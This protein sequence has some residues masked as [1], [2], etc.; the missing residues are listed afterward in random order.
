MIDI[1]SFKQDIADK[2]LSASNHRCVLC[3]ESNE[4][5]LVFHEIV[6][7]AIPNLYDNTGVD[8]FP[9]VP[10]EDRLVVL[11]RSC[12]VKIET[13]SKSAYVDI[14]ENNLWNKIPKISNQIYKPLFSGLLTNVRKM[15][16]MN[17]FSPEIYLRP[18]DVA[19]HSYWVALLSLA[20]ADEYL[21]D[22]PVNRL[23][24]LTMALFHDIVEIVTTDVPT[25]IK[26]ST[27]KTN[28]FY[29]IVE[30]QASKELEKSLGYHNLTDII[31]EVNHGESVEA[32]IVR[33][34]DRISAIIYASEEA[35]L[36]NRNF[37][38]IIRS[39][40]S[41]VIKTLDNRG[42]QPDWFIE[43]YEDIKNWLDDSISPT[44]LRKG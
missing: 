29:E 35:F 34:A 15:A 33:A 30:K 13:L 43:L 32:Q 40:Y 44:I 19:E 24:I 25:P 6:P 18:E 16:H 20:I 11:C 22:E 41:S 14:L 28:A 2:I 38:T 5:S 9:N 17:R 37:I 8:P 10:I 42:H 3:E 27:P 1:N 4:T 21:E 39:Y 36:G 26:R 12:A 23:K 31:E 7:K